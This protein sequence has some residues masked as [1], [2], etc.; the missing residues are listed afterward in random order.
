[1]FNSNNSKCNVTTPICA[2]PPPEYYNLRS[3]TVL[4]RKQ[5]QDTEPKKKVAEEEKAPLVS[6]GER[7]GKIYEHIRSLEASMK[8][9]WEEI[10]QKEPE[11][12]SE[13]SQEETGHEE[14]EQTDDEEAD[15][16]DTEPETYYNVTIR[17]RVKS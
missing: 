9:L 17:L 3:R 5:T 15:L 12:A 14:T 2:S 16:S 4:K 11:A 13:I 10:F 6:T 7:L 8:P 1:M